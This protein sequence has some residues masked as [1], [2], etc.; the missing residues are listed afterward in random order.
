MTDDA[1]IIKLPV[2]TKPSKREPVFKRKTIAEKMRLKECD[3]TDVSYVV[4]LADSQVECTKCGKK[5]NPMWVLEQLAMREHRF[6]EAER[7]YREAISRL[8]KRRKTKCTH[9]GEMTQIS[10]Y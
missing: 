6:H 4:D 2:H 8:E 10:H 9:C 1:K 5:L 3:H 7:T